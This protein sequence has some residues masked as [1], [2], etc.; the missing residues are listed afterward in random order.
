MHFF[1]QWSRLSTS[2]N[3][4]I[5]LPMKKAVSALIIALSCG[6]G[7]AEEPS[8][9]SDFRLTFGQLNDN[10]I[11]P[12]SA[13]VD[14]WSVGP[15]DQFTFS[16]V[17]HAKYRE[18]GFAMDHLAVTSRLFGY[19]LDLLRLAAAYDFNLSPW[20]LRVS[21]GMIFQGNLG[22]QDMQ[23]GWHQ[24]IQYPPV[25]LPYR[26]PGMAFYLGAGFKYTLFTLLKDS[27]LLDAFGDADLY[28]GV[29]PD[30]IR[31]GLDFFFRSPVF[32]AEVLAGL[33]GHFLL[34][35][36]LAPILNDGLI[37]SC[38]LTVRPFPVFAMSFGLGVFP[39]KNV[40]DDPAFRPKDYPVTFQFYYLFTVGE[41]APSIRE[42]IYP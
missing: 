30:F 39:V 41:K 33:E 36:S 20:L 2:G 40:T 7:F 19:R 24:V 37:A 22:G 32:E 31:G 15:D 8:L 28:T 18:W 3:H 14:G 9:L 38:L 23:N 1:R 25:T 10:L 27:L 21:G 35:D 6:F 42:F 26:E 13:A 4:G 11:C 29:G 16:T 34:S 12:Y 17:L 5:M